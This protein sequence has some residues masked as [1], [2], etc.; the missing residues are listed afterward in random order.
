MCTVNIKK[1]CSIYLF[2]FLPQ[3]QYCTG[4]TAD[5]EVCTSPQM[6]FKK[7]KPGLMAF[8]SDRRE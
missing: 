7:N 6:T 3:H 5:Y 1:S 8:V 2:I 4:I